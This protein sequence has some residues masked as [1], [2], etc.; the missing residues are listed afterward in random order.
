MGVAGQRCR[1]RMQFT[2]STLFRL[3]HDAFSSSSVVI[4]QRYGDV[5]QYS[6]DGMSL[7]M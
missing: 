1:G 3:R 4:W 5:M 6:G 7:E 2:S